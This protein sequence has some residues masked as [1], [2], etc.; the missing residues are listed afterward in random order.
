MALKNAVS[1][2]LCRVSLDASSPAPIDQAAA[3][4]NEGKAPLCDEYGRLVV[5][6]VGPPAPPV[7]TNRYST[8]FYVNAATGFGTP[9][10]TRVLRTFYSRRD[11]INLDKLANGSNFEKIR[12]G[13][14][15]TGRFRR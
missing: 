12:R 2:Q 15:K 1:E 4:G 5:V 9:Y 6:S 11:C 14:A 3:L 10:N 13:F 7:T 8:K